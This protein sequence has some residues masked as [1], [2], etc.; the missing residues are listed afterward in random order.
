MIIFFSACLNPS[1]IVSI[2]LSFVFN[3]SSSNSCSCLL[4]IFFVFLTHLSL[5][6]ISFFNS[7]SFHIL[8]LFSPFLIFISPSYFVL[9]YFPLL[10]WILVSYDMA[11]YSVGSFFLLVPF[12]PECFQFSFLM[13]VGLCDQNSF[14]IL[15]LV[16]SIF[17]FFGVFSLDVFEILFA[18]VH[19]YILFHIWASKVVVLV[20]LTMFSLI[21]VSSQYCFASCPFSSLDIFLL[22]IPFYLFS[23][24][25]FITLNA[26]NF[27]CLLSVM[28]LLLSDLWFDIL[29][30]VLVWEADVMSFWFSLWYCFWIFSKCYWSWCSWWMLCISLLISYN[31]HIIFWGG[32]IF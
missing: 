21:L 5:L 28:D 12:C 32:S 23:S 27:I 3:C 24:S 16:L 10:L 17:G 30:V 1:F 7:P 4:I 14:F 8:L 19:T 9:S 18:S 26:A 11:P 20:W 31:Y 22:V 13:I 6:L 25:F 15:I 29:L 2:T